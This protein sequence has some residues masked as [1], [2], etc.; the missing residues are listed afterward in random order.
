MTA[1][2]ER[3]QTKLFAAEE[4]VE[5]AAVPTEHTEL[6]AQLSSR[7]RL[8]TMSWSFS[9]WRGRVYGPLSD[10][11]RLAEDGL[12]AYAANPLHRAVEIDRS[13]YD[14]LPSN[15]FRHFAE[16]V[17]EDF[18][19]LVKAHQDCTIRR[20]PLHGRYGKK[21]GR[22]NPRHL[23]AA[24][25]SERVIAPTLEGLG[26]KLGVL[27]FQFSPEDLGP[28][29]VFA[30]RLKAFLAG[31]PKGVTYAVELRKRELL[32]AAYAAALE[33]AGAVHCHNAWS[34]MPSVLEQAKGMPP[35][36]RR[37]LVIRWLLRPTDNYRAASARFAPFDRIVEEDVARRV[38][39]ARLVGKA[40]RRDVPSFVVI[41]ND[42]EGCAP[43]SIYRLARAIAETRDAA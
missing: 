5:A 43:E 8:G 18:R 19:F 39:I 6:A 30:E 35:A 21:G 14:L 31:L 16:Q 13:Y 40:L 26:T 2:L 9:G 22:D 23:D 17:P 1:S 28:V 42:A 15:V 34:D 24:Y 27:L 38:A 20:Y 33:A 36:T 29:P 3:R 10:I 7:L 4:R 12:A 41:N 37:P 11:G 25:A 32:T